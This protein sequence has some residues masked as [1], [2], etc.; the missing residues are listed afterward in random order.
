[1]GHSVCGSCYDLLP[2]RFT[3]LNAPT[4]LCPI[5]RCDY[6]RP[7]GHNLLAEQQITGGGLVLDC[8]NANHG[9]LFKGVVQELEEH[10]V[11]CF[12]RTVPCPETDCQD[13]VRLSELDRHIATSP[14]HK[15]ETGN[16]DTM[17]MIDGVTF[18]KQ[19]VVGDGI[20]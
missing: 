8:D 17:G 5:A 18:Y 10:L 4:K 16:W 19:R 2:E 15:S 3:I 13:R 7:P 9:C 11:E 14:H 12:Y 6:D 20:R 1:M